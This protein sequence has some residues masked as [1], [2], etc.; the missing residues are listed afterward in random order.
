M[1]RGDGIRADEG[2]GRHG[3]H[4]GTPNRAHLR[5]VAAR[6]TALRI[7]S[8]PSLAL[9]LFFSCVVA[10]AVG[11]V[12]IP[13]STS[14][15]VLLNQTH[16]FHLVRTWPETHEIILLQLRL[17]RVAGAALVGAALGTAGALF[18]GLLR[19]P[20]ADPLLLGTSSGAALGATLA[21]VV[22]GLFALE[23]LGFSAVALFAFVGSIL[24]VALV[25]ALASRQSGTPVVTL[26]LAGVAVGAILSAGQTLLLTF[27]QRL[28]FRVAGL[29]YW[30][31]GS[32]GV[33]SWTQIA[34]MAPLV[35]LGVLVTVG[36]APILDAFALGEEMSR[37]LGISTERA[38]L[39]VV[40]V[41][42]VL[43]ACAVSISGL[44][45]FVGLVA[46]HLC[47]LALGPRHRILLPASALAGAT[48]VVLAD[49][50]A[51]TLAAP[52]ELPLGVITALV[53]GPFF[54]A[55]LRKAGRAYGW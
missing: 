22:P 3:G 41:A 6:L 52:S 35:V 25:Y 7:G 20:L 26:L 21:Y 38:K 46:P 44:V 48:F 33:Q 50:L 4:S 55:L 24:A 30:L 29:Y 36:L 34:V 54:L 16:L 9:A 40:T 51:R 39:A 53:G 17:P 14:A 43:V 2:P 28:G 47:R 42:S 8:L 27:N 18:Q 37:H 11:T 13:L 5:D 32:V 31:S 19:N 12:P 15:A 23:W 45:G 10:A 1:R 49:L